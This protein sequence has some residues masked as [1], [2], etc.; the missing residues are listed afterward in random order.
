MGRDPLAEL[1]AELKVHRHEFWGWIVYRCTYSSDSEWAKFK[2]K[3]EADSRKSLVHYAAT[4]AMIK[5][6]VWTFV[7][8][9]E[10]LENATKSNVRQI[11]NEWVNS[12]EAAA[13]QPNARLRP[14]ETRMARYRY[15]IHVDQTSLRSVLDDSRDWHLNLI[16][17]GWIPEEEQ[18]DDGDLEDDYDYDADLTEEEREDIRL[19]AI[20]PEIE[21]CTEEEVGWCKASRGVIVDRY[22]IHCDQGNWDMWYT[23]PPELAH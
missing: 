12:P 8:D 11:F 23:R 13:E 10:R 7:E 17:R 15:C 18:S 20:W 6:H 21:G 3:L 4:E 5:Q 19:A 1:D 16:D 2:E 9:R 14:S 22:L